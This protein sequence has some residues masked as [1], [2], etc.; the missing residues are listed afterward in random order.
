[1]NPLLLPGFWTVHVSRFD[2]S[3]KGHYEYF[4]CCIVQVG[5]GLGWLS[6]TPCR[7]VLWQP[8][9]SLL[10]LFHLQAGLM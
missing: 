2:R 4:G 10:I 3:D 7:L 9:P 1:M 5:R 8:L 6:P